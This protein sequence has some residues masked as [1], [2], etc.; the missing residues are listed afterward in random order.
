[1]IM[2][3]I[4]DFSRWA[5]VELYASRKKGPFQEM[6]KRI[7]G[8]VHAHSR[9]CHEAL[10]VPGMQHGRPPLCFRTDGEGSIMSRENINRML[11]KRQPI[12][13]DKTTAGAHGHNGVVE[14]AHRTII[15]I[16]RSLMTAVAWPIEHWS[17]EFSHAVYL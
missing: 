14:R 7:E 10:T 9:R 15:Q 8:R 2:L 12:D 6:L 17:M 16:T 4:D 3:C 13:I 5:T 1:M 11:A